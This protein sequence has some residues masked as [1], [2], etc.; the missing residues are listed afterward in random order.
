MYIY[1]CTYNGDHDSAEGSEVRY[2][3]VDPPPE[4]V[5]EGG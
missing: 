3:N 4:R 1:M 5:R 2:E